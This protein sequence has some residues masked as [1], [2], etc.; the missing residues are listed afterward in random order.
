MSHDGPVPPELVI[1]T[2]MSS[3]GRSTAASVLEDLGWYVVDNLPPQLLPTMLDVTSAPSAGVR[4][5]AAVVDVRSRSF[6]QALRQ[7]FAE[8]RE[9]GVHPRVVFLDASDDVLVRRQESVRRPHPLQGHGRI[10]DGIH[11]E[12]QL[13][14]NLREDADVLVDTSGLNVTQLRAKV[15][16]V[17][18]AGGL[19]LLRATVMSFGF[20]Y[21]VPLDADFVV[22]VRFLPNP[23]WVPELRPQSGL[24]EPVSA[25][26]LAQG[27]A[28]VFL[29][30]FVE[31]LEPVVAGY[32]AEGK[33]YV[34]ICVGCTG[35]K[36]RSVAMVRELAGR[37][38]RLGVQVGTL[39]R[40][41][42]RE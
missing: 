26:V 11:R 8:L 38:S 7:S 5:L 39:H 41:L 4:Q 14:E 16:Q 32:Q 28:Q 6:F 35:G 1:V 13:L 29:D 12:R 17:F 42:G 22:D 40:D 21:G 24:D 34:T 2:G 30:R 19:P 20:K 9:R 18:E 27:G 37:L 33:R 3:A 10:L 23:H 36:H 25:F 31:S 15:S